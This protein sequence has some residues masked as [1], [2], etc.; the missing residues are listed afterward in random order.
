MRLHLI[1]QSRLTTFFKQS[2]L[3]TNSPIKADGVCGYLALNELFPLHFPFA[4]SSLPLGSWGARRCASKCLL[5]IRENPAGVITAII[6][7][8]NKTGTD[9]LRL[10]L[11]QG[12][13]HTGGYFLSK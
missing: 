8:M 13:R 6:I 3:Q 5:E 7:S 2:L 12:R 4:L 11:K 1:Q 9:V 10:G